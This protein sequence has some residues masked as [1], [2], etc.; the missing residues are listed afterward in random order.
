MRF[1]GKHISVPAIKKHLRQRAA[2]TDRARLIVE[3]LLLL[4]SSIIVVGAMR[5][6]QLPAALMLGPMIAAIGFALGGA[7]EKPNRG[8]HRPQHERS[9]Q[10]SS[11]HGAHYNDRAQEQEQPFHDQPCAVRKRCTLP[12]MLFYCGHGYVFTR[13]PHRWLS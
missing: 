8:Y 5:A 6:A 2:L 13:K 10:L 9:G 11:T 12:E 7:K 4:L 1:S 3:W